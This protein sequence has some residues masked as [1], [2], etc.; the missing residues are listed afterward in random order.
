MIRINLLGKKK[1]AA[2]PFGLDEKLEKFGVSFTDFNELRPALVR[3]LVLFA[4]LYIANYVPTYLHEEKIKELDEK[5]TKLAQKSAE[6]QKELNTK[7]DIRKQMEQL[8]KEEVE[9]Q[10][11]LNAVNALQR[12]RASAFSTLNDIVQQLAKTQKVWVEDLKYENRK[13][14]LNGRS[15]EYFPVNDF[16]KSITESTRYTNVL[17]REIA[18]EEAKKPIAGVPE[19]L[20]KTKKFNLEFTVR[21]LE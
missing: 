5:Q 2:M 12:D 15:W 10:R 7:K 17:F 1:V 14:T 21:E 16:V 20:Q 6:L 3:L 11:Q 18:A 13:I 19:A 8:N 9:L 4:G